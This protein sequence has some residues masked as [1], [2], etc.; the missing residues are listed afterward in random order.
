[1]EVASNKFRYQ[2]L[3]RLKQTNLI[4]TL[5]HFGNLIILYTD[6][7]TTFIEWTIGRYVICNIFILTKQNKSP[8]CLF[9][10]HCLVGMTAVFLISWPLSSGFVWHFWS[11]DSELVCVLFYSSGHNFLFRSSSITWKIWIEHSFLSKRCGS[12][13]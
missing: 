12:Y 5:S 13:Y 3:S 8:L 7:K 1:M 2:Q 11:N 4:I 9:W 6:P 10:N